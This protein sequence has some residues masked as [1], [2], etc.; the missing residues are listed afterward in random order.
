MPFLENAFK[1]S[2]RDDNRTNRI[3]ISLQQQG[4]QIHFSCFN[5]FEAVDMPAG[6]I[7]LNNV[8][9]RLELL[10]KDRYTLNIQVEQGIYAVDLNLML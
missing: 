4:N 5:S 7:G 8:R 10:Y 6:G 3:Q 2:T 1:F 9:R